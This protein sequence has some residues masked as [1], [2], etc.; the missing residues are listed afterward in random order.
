MLRKSLL[1]AA[2]LALSSPFAMANTITS[3]VC[4]PGA[5][6]FSVTATSVVS[7]LAAGTG[8]IN[9]NNQADAFLINSGWVCL[10]DSTGSGGAEDGGL[11]GTLTSG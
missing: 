8:N 11:S 9:G 5:R 4:A 3:D 1:A 2:L 6:D 7:C 10:N